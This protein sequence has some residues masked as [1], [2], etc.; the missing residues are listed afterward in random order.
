VY[1]APY[2]EAD[3]LARTIDGRLRRVSPETRQAVLLNLV[4]QLDPEALDAIAGYAERI[5]RARENDGD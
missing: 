2:D 1:R 3:Y 4:D 5:R